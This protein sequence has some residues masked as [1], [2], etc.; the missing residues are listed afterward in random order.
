VEVGVIRPLI[1]ILLTLVVLVGLFVLLRPNQSAEG[2]Q[3]REV[4]GLPPEA[5]EYM[6]WR[7]AWQPRVAAAHTI[8][9]EL[10]AVKAYRFDPERVGNSVFTAEVLTFV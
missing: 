8:P 5:V 10:R 2:P 3:R 6:L 1:L 7:P 9:R 4:A